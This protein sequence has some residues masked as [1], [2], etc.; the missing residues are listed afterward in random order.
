MR[1]AAGG[2]LLA[3][4][5]AGWWAGLYEESRTGTL[6]AIALLAA[7]P[8]AAVL[9]VCGE[10]G[11]RPARLRRA[12]LP[13]A[14]GAVALTGLAA[15]VTGR[16]PL[17]FAALSGDAWRDLA[18]VLPDG[19]AA[20]ET[21]ST[22]AS[23]D[24]D[25]AF[26]RLLDLALAGL[27]GGGVWLALVR[28]RAGAAVVVAGAGVAYRWTVEAPGAA[29]AAGCLTL[30]VMLGALAL[31][32]PGGA[33]PGGARARS[34][35][36]PGAPLRAAGTLAVVIAV[37]GALG[38]GPAQD[39]R[40]WWDWRDW[41]TGDVAAGAGLD[42]QQNY[43]QL[44]WPEV[45][46]EVLRVRTPRPLPMR[47]I[48]L[49]A[50]DGAAF[51]WDQSRGSRPVRVV[52][53]GATLRYPAPGASAPVRQSVTLAAT[54]AP[55]VLAGG[56][57]LQVR[58]GL[59]GQADEVGGE[60]LRVAPALGPGDSYR[61]E[62]EVPDPDPAGLIG[63]RGY[64]P[65]EVEPGTTDV[66]AGPGGP[67]L[68]VPLW[69]T[70]GTAPT[71][72]ELGEY[73]PVRAL[74]RRV[75][76]DAGSPYVA[77]NRIEAHL[78]SDYAYDEAPPFPSPGT[79]PLADFLFTT[80]RGFCQ[81]FAGSMALM[82][83][84]LGIPARVAVGYTAGRL[85]PESGDWVV[86]DRD[87]HAWVEVQLPGAGWVPFDPTPGR[88]APNR[89]S[90][91]SPDYSPP[92]EDAPAAES[93]TPA[94]VAVPPDAAPAQAAPVRPEPAA[95]APDA[96]AA[97]G[98]EGDGGERPWWP[99]AAG[100]AVLGLVGAAPAGRALRRA[101]RRRLP[102][103]RGRVLGAVAD[104][105]QDLRALGAAPA[106]TRDAAGRAREL[107]E[108][109]GVDARGLYR[110]AEEA[111]YGRAEPSPGSGAAAWREARRVRRQVAARRGRLRRA[112]AFV[113]LARHGT[114][115]GS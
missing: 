51:T 59:G 100:L 54:E 39:G 41:G 37:A 20:G 50:F 36:R 104:L 28:R 108:R 91:G 46:R 96:P 61:V 83:R 111:C 31:I 52:A 5:L 48:A 38:T 75:A 81:H 88:Y 53:G 21:A 24:D 26:I 97:A 113:G 57:L 9:A 19:L 71:D 33:P 94:P 106:P 49:G 68:T 109:F 79:P 105:E 89:V 93:V 72:A 25:A 95:P 18:R 112:A 64:A 76:G 66:R 8:A 67:A 70:G 27:V 102:D 1:A 34:V 12:L 92:E 6:L 45:P 16:G 10:G 73:A 85:E 22:P 29:L 7:L 110:R 86:L 80:R 115:D 87:A 13:V 3:L 32:A 77:V 11:R 103:E 78:R 69:G 15:A 2:A 74:A 98:A 44:R 14:A 60:G 17:E 56:R 99:G 43:G 82:L 40:G 114:L 63:A 47:A 35:R 62:V 107:Q 65:G 90:V 58:G 101:R 55:L 42:V 4:L 23:P 30:A 84:T